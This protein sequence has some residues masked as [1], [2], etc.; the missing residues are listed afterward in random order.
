M[1]IFTKKIFMLSI[2]MILSTCAFAQGATQHRFPK[3]EFVYEGSTYYLPA[4]DV[5]D[6]SNGRVRI[7]AKQTMESG[8]TVDAMIVSRGAYDT[9]HCNMYTM[10]GGDPSGKTVKIQNSDIISSETAVN[11][12]TITYGE[13]FNTVAG[14]DKDVKVFDVNVLNDNSDEVAGR[15]IGD[16]SVPS[17]VEYNGCTLTI[18]EIGPHAYRNNSITEANNNHVRITNLTIPN[19]VK[20]ID[21]EA[22]RCVIK[23]TTVN[24]GTGVEEL[25][26]GA[27][28]NCSGLTSL[29]FPAS[30]T[31]LNGASLSGC[32]GIKDLY[33]ESAPDLLPYDWKGKNKTIND[34]N[35]FG[36]MPAYTSSQ[37]P[38]PLTVKNCLVHVPLGSANTFS[39]FSGLGFV[40]T[41]KLDHKKEFTT[42]CSN[43]KFTTSKYSKGKWSDSGLTSYYV[44]KTDVGANSVKLTQIGTEEFIPAGCGVVLGGEGG[45]SKKYDIYYPAD[46]SELSAS[47]NCLIG[48]TEE[49]QIP[50]TND[51]YY[52]ILSDGKFY[53]VTASGTLGANKAYIKISKTSNDDDNI[54]VASLSLSLPE[55]TGVET[56]EVK[57]VQNDSWYTLQGIQV[58]QPSKGIFIKNGKKFVIK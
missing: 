17:S 32:S 5:L 30:L 53:P 37:V 10:F 20:K 43:T 45:E 35:F 36:G 19:T 52:Y 11:V 47:D 14:T 34:I 15:I 58:N 27:F 44:K 56:Y 55:D 57:N 29:S 7:Q 40:L 6:E 16:Y 3:V 1:K 2:G 18:T 25:E 4:W 46:G 39:D 26:P 38:T 31:Y 48:V 28:N 21:I 23:M 33:F 41:S 54:P 50:V 49:T 42:Y 24:L 9:E 8:A 12:S 13:V 51:F 22:F